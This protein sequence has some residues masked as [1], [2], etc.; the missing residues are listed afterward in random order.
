MVQT[1]D[2]DVGQWSVEILQYSG[3]KGNA[4]LLCQDAHHKSSMYWFCD[5][6]SSSFGIGCIF[7]PFEDIAQSVVKCKTNIALHIVARFQL[8]DVVLLACLCLTLLCLAVI[9]SADVWV[10]PAGCPL[11]LTP[12]TFNSFLKCHVFKD[13]SVII[14][15][16]HLQHTKTLFVLFKGAFLLSL[17]PRP[18]GF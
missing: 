18:I 16:S 17:G 9:L 13:Q 8:E 2:T 6:V 10:G 3:F 14:Y 11:T 12:N 5:T 4:L 15:S 7:F 1:L